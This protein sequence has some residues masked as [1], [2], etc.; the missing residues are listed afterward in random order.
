MAQDG[1]GHLYPL[2]RRAPGFTSTKQPEVCF[3]ALLSDGAHE[4]RFEREAVG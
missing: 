2:G 1:G 4:V 3:R